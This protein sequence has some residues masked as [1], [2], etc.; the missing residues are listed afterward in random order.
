VLEE[1]KQFQTQAVSVLDYPIFLDRAR[2]LRTQRQG[3]EVNASSQSL[4]IK[5]KA[6]G[7]IR[8]HKL[9]LFFVVTRLI[10]LVLWLIPN[11]SEGPFYFVFSSV[12]FVILVGSQLFWIARVGDI[13]KRLIPR[14]SWR[15]GLALAGLLIYVFV[16]SGI[17]REFWSNRRGSLRSV[18][19]SSPGACQRQQGS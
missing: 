13:D 12:M 18:L 7:L 16:V 17:Y 5:A 10:F 15:S 8:A 11:W 2:A 19:P 14:K 1:G 6:I 4:D 3:H 9:I